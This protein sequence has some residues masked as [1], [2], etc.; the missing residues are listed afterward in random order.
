MS[1]GRNTLI[2]RAGRMLQRLPLSWLRVFEFPVVYARRSFVRQP[3]LL[4]LLAVPRS[5]S[6]VTY[7]MLTHRFR[8][9]YLSNFG[10]I[11]YHLPLFGGLFASRY[12]RSYQTNFESSYGFVPGLC[13]QAEGLRFWQYWL[14]YNLDER[15]QS[16]KVYQVYSRRLEYLR[17]TFSLLSHKTLPFV[18]GFL[19]HAM[20]PHRLQTEF[21]EALFIRLYRDPLSNAM[22]LLQCRRHSGGKWFSSFPSESASAVGKGEHE[23][24]ASQVYWLNRRL[25]DQLTGDNVYSLDYEQLCLNPVKQLKL[26]QLFCAE[27][28]VELSIKNDIP[29]S[30]DYRLVQAED[31]EDSR[32]LQRALDELQKCHGRLTHWGGRNE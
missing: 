21:P 10:N 8:T 13:G 12:C 4:F 23:E 16:T 30:F 26:L 27:K 17:R 11:L 18:S 15:Q 1:G 9:R 22:S 29:Q 6:T 20:Q 19:G 28:G 14:G 3:A 2:V 7:Q 25:D 31:S 32:L 5:G 24:V